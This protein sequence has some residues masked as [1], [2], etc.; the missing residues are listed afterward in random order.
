MKAQKKLAEFIRN[1]SWYELNKDR[2]FP[3]DL[4]WEKISRLGRLNTEFIDFYFFFLD[5]A[6]ISQHQELSEELMRKRKDGLVWKTI[7]EHQELSP[8]FISEMEDVLHWP[9]LFKRYQFNEEFLAKHSDKLKYPEAAKYQTFTQ[10]LLYLHQHT[11][12]L[13]TLL[14]RDDV[15]GHIWEFANRLSRMKKQFA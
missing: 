5:K 10:K 14:D 1:L 15:P 11:I 8:D 2:N 4:G 3:N 13:E 7:S 6:L 9:T 12:D